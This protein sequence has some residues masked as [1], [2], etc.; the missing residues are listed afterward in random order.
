MN[1]HLDRKS[2]VT[3]KLLAW[4]R[5]YRD[6]SRISWEAPLVPLAQPYPRG[7]ERW[8]EWTPEALS[9]VDAA[10]LSVLLEGL[11][12]RE[13]SRWPDFR[14]DRGRS[15]KVVTVPHEL[16]RW[17]LWGFMHLRLP[18]E[19]WGYFETHHHVPLSQLGL[20]E[21]LRATRWGGPISF[22]HP[23]WLVSRVGCHW[24]THQR[25][26]MPEVESRLSEIDAWMEWSC[27]WQK[28]RRLH[29]RT[30]WRAD[31]RR[32]RL[33]AA[34]HR[35]EAAD[36]LQAWQQG[37][38]SSAPFSWCPVSRKCH[39]VAS[40]R[41][42]DRPSAAAV[43]DRAGCPIPAVATRCRGSSLRRKWEKALVVPK[44]LRSEGR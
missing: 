15:R 41:W 12:N 24:I 35:R 16:P 39:R 21:E 29:G 33:V 6:L 22:R 34:M 43:R 19:L 44:F 13:I 30:N 28:L 36:E 14:R 32:A 7:W 5:E 11:Q 26:A 8:F 25:V 17:S 2:A 10:H 20:L 27:G 38:E 23:Q 40:S 1:S 42:V 4:E 37:A 3:K 31:R 9:R 18:A